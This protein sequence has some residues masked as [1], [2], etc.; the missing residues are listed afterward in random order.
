MIGLIFIFRHK[1]KNINNIKFFINIKKV[2]SVQVNNYYFTAEMA[3]KIFRAVA[4]LFKIS[5]TVIQ[6]LKGHKW[7]MFKY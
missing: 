4:V 5:E 3:F 6:A 7:D 2:I 1:V